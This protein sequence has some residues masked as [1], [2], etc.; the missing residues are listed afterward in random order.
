MKCLPK[1]RLD[2]E[3]LFLGPIFLLPF[4]DLPEAML[5]M[6]HGCTCCCF[7]LG[8]RSLSSHEGRTIW[9]PDGLS[10]VPPNVGPEGPLWPAYV[11]KAAKT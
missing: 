7:V 10:R 4:P 1:K 6:N 5:T 3:D 11:F 2:S 8:I 9:I